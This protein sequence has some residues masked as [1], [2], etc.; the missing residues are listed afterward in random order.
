M[1]AVKAIASTGTDLDWHGK[2]QLSRIYFKCITKLGKSSSFD[3]DWGLP[4]HLS[5]TR[6]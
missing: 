5:H 6:Y 4:N 2:T 1:H 3:R